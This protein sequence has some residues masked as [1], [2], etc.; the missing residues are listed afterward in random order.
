MPCY[1]GGPI[2]WAPLP[3]DA[4]PGSAPTK[5]SSGP[6]TRATS[7]QLTECPVQ[8]GVRHYL[9]FDRLG[10]KL[11]SRKRSPGRSK[12]SPACFSMNRIPDPDLGSSRIEAVLS[13]LEQRL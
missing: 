2:A 6:A 12:S 1:L 8:A 9:F 4:C 3:C 11:Q 10:C 5:P 7:N 13:K